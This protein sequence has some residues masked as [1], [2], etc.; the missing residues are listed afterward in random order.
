VTTCELGLIIWV[1]II[2]ACL[3][4]QV[5]KDIRSTCVHSRMDSVRGHAAGTHAYGCARSLWVL[6]FTAFRRDDMAA[7][8]QQREFL[9][10]SAALLCAQSP[11]NAQERGCCP[12]DQS[13]QPAHRRPC[14]WY[15]YG[16]QQSFCGFLRY[17]LE[18]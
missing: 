15:L 5:D 17:F 1:N 7:A 3:Q 18:S 16:T 8:Q 9:N 13:Q 11:P 4:E 14:R 2:A 6:R 12:S 10:A